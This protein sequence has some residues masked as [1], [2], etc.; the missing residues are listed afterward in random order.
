MNRRYV[1]WAMIVLLSGCGQSP[2]RGTPT[3]QIV[4]GTEIVG[5]PQTPTATVSPGQTLVF[6]VQV[7]ADGPSSDRFDVRATPA[8]NVLPTGRFGGP[9][10]A[11]AAAAAGFT[12]VW[13]GPQLNGDPT[14]TVIDNDLVPAT[15]NL[16]ASAGATSGGFK[17]CAQNESDAAANACSYLYLTVR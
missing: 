8:D 9:S 7:F 3:V 2:V 1:P 6:E 13:A 10:D 17:V 12:V 15:L 16:T 5:V 14:A 4:P 11:G